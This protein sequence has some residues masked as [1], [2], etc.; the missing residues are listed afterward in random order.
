MLRKT[1]SG[2]LL[3]LLINMR[4]RFPTKRKSL[5]AKGLK[6]KSEKRKE[7]NETRKITSRTMLTLMLMGV[8]IFGFNSELITRDWTR[9]AFAHL[10]GLH[11]SEMVVAEAYE[12][13]TVDPAW[14]YD[15]PSSE[16]IS[17]VYETLIRFERDGDK[18]GFENFVPCLATDWNISDDGLTYNFT[19]RENVPWHDPSYGFM[20]AEDVEYSFER[21]MVHDKDPVVG[22]LLY[23]PLLGT[24]GANLTDPI[25]QGKAIDDAVTVDGNTVAFHLKR[26]DTS[27]APYTPFIRILAQSLWSQIVCKQWC[28]DQGDWPGTWDNWVDYHNLDVSP[29]E[30]PEPSMM[31]TGPYML[32]YWERGVEYSLIK[33][34]D[35]WG[36]WPAPGSRG[37]VNRVI[38]KNIPE[39]ATR[40]SMFL[41]GDADMIDVSRDKID[42]I[43]CEP[44][45]DCVYPLWPL[46]VYGLLFKYN[47]SI[48]SPFLGSGFDPANPYEIA[49]DRIRIDFFSDINVRKAFAHSFDG[50]ELILEYFRCEAKERP[51]PVIPD[52]P[53]YNSSVPIYEFDLAKAEEHFRQAWGGELWEKGFNFTIPYIGSWRRNA[54]ELIKTNVESL[55]PMFHIEV[56]EVPGPEY[57]R[58]CTIV[59]F[60]WCE[61]YPDP[62]DFVYPFMHSELGFAPYQRVQYGQSERKQIYPYGN[63]EMVINNTYV[64]VLIEAGLTIPDGAERERIYNE[65]QQIY[66]EECLSVFLYQPIYRHF[67]RDWV[68]GWYYNRIGCGDYLYFY[69]MWKE[70]LIPEDINEDGKVNIT[71]LFKVAKAFGSSYRLCEDIHPRWDSRSDVNCDQEVNITD[72]YE[73]AKDY[74]KT[75]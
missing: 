66:H 12:P 63:P 15:D 22:Y 52:L 9:P 5:T 39:W 26:L 47:I 10:D 64:D 41:E 24:Y 53:Y 6:E 44:E 3:F 65:L 49:G 23:E 27:Y 74:G 40:K 57:M 33:F 56:R 50:T 21:T 68:N 35:Y 14:T 36:G 61:D 34:D 42:E 62:H 38:V 71:D 55:N 17:N 60:G 45:I 28:I 51:T 16:L 18:D 73:V 43:F 67:Q 31:G 7:E 48:T 54:S 30:D 69:T 32:D 1:V 20:T 8:L 25:E 13:I 37:W 75:V 70:H 19:I 72:L 46:S 29:L 59:M 11:L 4:A 2:I 58:I